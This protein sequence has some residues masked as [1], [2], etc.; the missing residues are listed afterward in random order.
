MRGRLPKWA[1]VIAGLAVLFHVYFLLFPLPAGSGPLKKTVGRDFASY[2][3]AVQVAA[4]GGDPYEVEALSAA[5]RADETRDTVHPF[6]Y[7]PPFLLAVAW[8]LPLDLETGYRIAY[9]L[10][11]L[12]L[13]A[14]MLALWWWWRPLGSAVP[15]SIVVWASLM[16]PVSYG[17][18][19]GQVNGMILALV[20]AGLWLAETK[21]E[22]PGGFLVGAACM[23][24]MS[25][26][27]FV[28]WWLIRGRR[29]AAAAAIG[30][31]FVLSIAAL[32][33]VGVGGQ[34]RFYTEILPAFGSGDYNGLIVKIGMF[35]N[36]SL[37]NLADQLLPGDGTRLGAAAQLLSAG[38][39]LA[40]LAA[41]G[42]K[43]RGPAT[44]E[45]IAAQAAALFAIALLIP[46]YTYEH[47][48]V[49]A[50]PAMALG[51]VLAWRGDLP[52]WAGVGIVAAAITLCL[53]HQLLKPLAKV[54]LGEPLG[55]F[56]Q[57]AKFVSLLVLLGAMFAVAAN[58]HEPRK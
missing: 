36:H 38:I 42:W 2:Y 26:A 32:P 13:I 48:L 14:A 53:P 5:A 43:F 49:F 35:A 6:F 8:A 54:T 40:L 18:L 7:P 37:P 27:L 4:S 44:A 58:L 30:A 9:W 21:R 11:E 17:H 3:Y 12:F 46:V 34:I 1:F 50:L 22:I 23:F 15:L 39:S 24:K 28:A 31:A 52:R 55:W 20:I 10:D 16:L 56:V 19:M 57:E 45:R 41:C 51:S 33:F 47:H 29:R 25:P